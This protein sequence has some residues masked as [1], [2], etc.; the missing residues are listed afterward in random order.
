VILDQI[1]R[2]KRVEICAR[3]RKIPFTEIR[4]RAE[5]G[6]HFRPRS[7]YASIYQHKN[8]FLFS[9][10]NGKADTGLPAV[11]AEIKRASPSKGLIR[12]SVEIAD[13]VR[14][15][16]SSGAA[17]ISVLT[18]EKFFSGSLID[19]EKARRATCLPLL[20]KDF[21]IDHYQVYEAAVYGADAILLIVTV[22]DDAKLKELY[23]LAQSIGLECLV[24]VHNEKELKRALAMGARIIGINNRDLRS[25]HIDIGTTFALAGLIRCQP[26]APGTLVVSESGISTRQDLLELYKCGVDAVLIGEALMRCPDPGEKLRELLGS[27]G[28]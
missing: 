12:E 15:Y 14:A 18:D 1:V 6:R 27:T 4:A 26:L 5:S 23:S 25:F 21:I 17:A 19:L 10:V 3:R 28:N 9:E 7:L 20:C 22:L 16:E 11:I 8:K 2:N 24:E 13:I